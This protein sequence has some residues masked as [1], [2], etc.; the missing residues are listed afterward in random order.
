MLENIAY[1][2]EQHYGSYDC[3]ICTGIFLTIPHRLPAF[4]VVS[5]VGKKK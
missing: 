3:G 2:N 4:Y 1:E 5:D